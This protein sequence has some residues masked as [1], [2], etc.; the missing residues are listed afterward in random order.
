[1][2]S[3]PPS[4]K[5]RQV[6]LPFAIASSVGNRTSDSA[7]DE[8]LGNERQSSC[9]SANADCDGVASD[10]H[11]HFAGQTVTCDAFMLPARSDGNT[12]TDTRVCLESELVDGI[13]QPT[14]V[15]E[16]ERFPEQTCAG[17]TRRF[18]AAW[19]KRFPWLHLSKSLRAA[20]CYPCAKGQNMSLARNKQCNDSQRRHELIIA[21]SVL[22]IEMSYERCSHLLQ[23]CKIIVWK[24]S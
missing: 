22:F 5:F 14:E 9:S 23:K 15:S 6:T 4:K 19:F 7:V 16:L 11:L 17:K 21:C 18:Q 8:Q 20:V 10:R 24:P 2:S 13:H 3:I 12:S 1:M